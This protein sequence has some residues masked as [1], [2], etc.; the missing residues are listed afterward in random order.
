MSKKKRVLFLTEASYLSTGYATYGREVLT[1]LQ[2][3]KKYEVAEFSVYGAADDPRRK[4]L[5][6]KNYANMP[7][8]SQEQQKLYG[9]N[10]INQFGAWRFE[11]A[12]LDFEPDI[13]LCIRDFWMDSFVWHSPYR[14]IF[15]WAW[16][17]T[18]DASPQ[19]VEWVDMFADADYLLTYS[20]WA[21][22]VLR[23][24]GGDSINLYGTA[25]PSASE[26]FKPIN[27]ARDILGIPSDWKIVGTVM[28]NQRRK[29]FPA[30]LE[31][32]SGYLHSSGDLNTYLYCH[33]SYP[34]AGWN[35]SELLHEHKISS[36]VLF[37]Y[38][39]Q[40]CGKLDVSK[41]HDSRKLCT[42]CR[43]YASAPVSVSNG[44]DNETLA[45]IY[46]CFDLYIQCAN[47][48]GFGLPQ[49][50]A[51][52][53]GVPIACTYY[54]AMED[55]VHKLGAYPI[56]FN[57]YKE[58][59]T[60]CD[61]AVPLKDDIINTF[62]IFFHKK[63]QSDRD[64]LGKS[65]RLLFEQNYSWDTTAEQWARIIDDCKYADWKQPPI[66]YPLVDIKTDQSSHS[67]FIKDML[68]AYMY[69]GSHKHSHYV[70]NMYAS[71][72]RGTTRM[73]FDGFFTSDFTPSNDSKQ[74][75]ID[76]QHLV[77]FM[78]KR[79]ENYN[80]WEMVRADRSKLIDGGAEWLN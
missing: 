16:M 34:D 74:A 24:Q 48:E 18:V 13:V 30:L 78:K 21:G 12:C 11:R 42:G 69:T 55:V 70:R 58:L 2:A 52:A 19:N 73:N 79:L 71:L 25:S 6:W 9:A 60:G 4:S 33:T 75:P 32:F 36:R 77:N 39:C 68:N 35:I 80:V 46:N 27:N 57:K 23:K 37:S 44:V 45:Q 62:N 22:G 14:R 67:E 8:H 20:D 17:P 63:S 28:R 5:R 61:R 49:V 66:I 56:K 1:R 41:F 31:A 65:T 10:S 15:E 47:S 7:D 43:D 40:G 50:E 38:K 29:L 3:S 64:A 59:E 72:C 76:R 26:E 53:C 51:A 54:S